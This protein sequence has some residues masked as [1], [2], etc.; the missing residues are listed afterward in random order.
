MPTLNLFNP[1]KS[2]LSLN[3]VRLTILFVA[4][5]AAIISWTIVESEQLYLHRWD[6]SSDGWNQFVRT[7]QVPLGLIAFLIPILAFFAANHRSEQTKEQIIRT[8]SSS[9][10]SNFL[11]HRTEL[12]KEI[13]SILG[14]AGKLV[15]ENEKQLYET[16]YPRAREGDLSLNEDLRDSLVAILVNSIGVHKALTSGDMKIIWLMWE[17]VL[18]P[19]EFLLRLHSEEDQIFGYVPETDSFKAIGVP[20]SNVVGV[21]DFEKFY[22]HSKNAVEIIAGL[23][24]TDHVSKSHS[25]QIELAID[26]ARKCSPPLLFKPNY[27]ESYSLKDE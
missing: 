16:L 1:E 9:N 10:F 17:K 27:F 13:R 22:E 24:R 11:A 21:P 25:M 14:G 12:E 5:L 7:F 19:V 4:G 6:T 23:L 15:V 26:A 8:T 3:V 2:L 18:R 20:R